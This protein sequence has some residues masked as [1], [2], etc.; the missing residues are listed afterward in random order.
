MGRARHGLGAELGREPAVGG[1]RD[2]G[3]NPWRAHEDLAHAVE[4][5]EGE[6][7]ARLHRTSL[8]TIVRRPSSHTLHRGVSNPVWR[9]NR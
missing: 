5:L 9:S 6:V 1:Q 8:D 2:A 7:E 4:R 3:R